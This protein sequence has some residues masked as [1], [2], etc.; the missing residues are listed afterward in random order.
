MS[1]LGWCG[2]ALLAA[3]IAV[4]PLHAQG[5]RIATSV[6]T[7]LVTVGDRIHLTVTV[8][9]AADARAVWPDSLDL[10]PFEVLQAEALPPL[11]EG[12][13]V[14]VGIRLTL[15]AFELGELEIPSFEVGVEGSNTETQTLSTDRFGVEVVSV[16]TDESGDIRDIRGP[17]AIPVG[18]VTVSL[19]LL[20]LLA[21]AV[22][23]WSF[24]RRRQRGPETEP[25]VPAVPVLSPEEVALEALGRIE[26]SDLLARGEVKQYH[27]E[28]SD[29]L[30]HYVEA[31]FEV[32]ALEM[33][34]REVTEGLRRA[35]VQ[36]AFREDL[37]RLLDQCDLVKFA[38]V[39]PDAEDSRAVLQLGRTLV[40][41]V[42]TPAGAAEVH[43]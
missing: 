9:H 2:C 27:I 39:R 14:R 8:E 40:T 35:G 24:Y 16:G 38:K 41:T 22:L 31:R 25:V 3:T 18:V 21:V 32:P 28:V 42:S 4:G 5:A 36:Q 12:D 23:A 17:F 34:T 10:A 7:T 1:R 13:A 43:A 26:A 11:A 6:D 20:A 30:R 37:R 15:A 29:V 19:W 33:T